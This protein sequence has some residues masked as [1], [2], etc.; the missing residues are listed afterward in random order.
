MI[1]KI[2]IFSFILFLCLFSV[3]CVTYD[4]PIP[5]PEQT[6]NSYSYSDKEIEYFTEIA[7]GTEYGNN[8]EVVRKWDSDIRI[9]IKGDP[10]EKDIESLNQVISDINGII[11]DKVYLTIVNTNENININFVSLSDFSICNA[12]P[13]N[14][15]Y[16]NCRWRNNVIYGCDICIATDDSLLQEERSHM[17]REELTQSLGLMRDSFKYRD[18]IFYE[19]WTQT[20]NYSEIDR[21]MIEILYLDDVWLGMSKVEVERILKK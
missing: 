6:Q 16:F 8:I 14:Y 7:L 12:K 5:I 3:C 2:I 21:K 19:G 1:S 9:K 10:N 17:I 18:S 11:G 4:G 15:G 13:G 20:L